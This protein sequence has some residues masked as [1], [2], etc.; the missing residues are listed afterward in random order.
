MSEQYAVAATTVAT[1]GY[2]SGAG[3]LNV[4]DTTGFVAPSRCYI[5][6]A[7]TGAVKVILQ[8][9]AINSGTQFAVAA[10]GTDAAAA[11]GD[12]VVACLTTGGMN[13]IRADSTR[14]ITGI[15]PADGYKGD[16]LHPSDDSLLYVADSGTGAGSSWQAFGPLYSFTPPV[17]ADF[18]WVF[19]SNSSVDTRNGAIVLNSFPSSDH[20]NLYAKSAPGSTPFTIIAALSTMFVSDCAAGFA[21]RDSSG[22]RVVTL[23]LGSNSGN[24]SGVSFWNTYSSWASGAANFTGRIYANPVWIR[25][26]VTATTLT[27]SFGLD[28]LVWH[29]VYSDSLTTWLPG[30]PDQAGVFLDAYTATGGAGLILHSWQES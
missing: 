18:S 12:D 15:L 20:L 16:T 14:I 25:C 24:G 26:D 10:E 13:A 30:V 6:D 4:A 27:F 5:A 28:G 2:T 8:I 21:L 1:G 17:A 29:Q 3:V 23:W 9:T 7:S 19:E 22:G 11:S